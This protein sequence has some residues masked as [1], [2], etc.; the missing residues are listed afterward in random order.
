[1]PRKNPR[2]YYFEATDSNGKV[3]NLKTMSDVMR[4]SGRNW[5]FVSRR[6]KMNKNDFSGYKIFKR[7]YLEG[8]KF[9]TEYPI[10]PPI[11]ANNNKKFEDDEYCVLFLEQGK[12]LWYLSNFKRLYRSKLMVDPLDKSHIKLKEVKVKK[13][14]YKLFD[15]EKIYQ[16]KFVEWRK[17]GIYRE[18]MELILELIDTILVPDQHKMSKTFG[19]SSI[20]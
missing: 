3:Y 5:D 13:S 18:D 9:D 8:I 11:K 14:D 20:K 15:I 16:E 19:R 2:E 4:I 12:D 7:R 6:L 17:T 10:I 1:M